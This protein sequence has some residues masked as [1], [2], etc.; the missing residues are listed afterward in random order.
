MPIITI[1]RGSYSKGKEVAE[2]VAQRLGYECISREVLVEASDHF[3]IPEIKLVRALHDAPSILERFTYGKERYLAYIESAFLDRVQNDNVVY[4]GLAGHFFLRGVG[5]VLKVRILADIEDRIRLEM[6]RE[7]IS[8]EQALYILKKDDQERRQWSMRLF[9]ADSWDSSLYDLVIHVKKLK[10]ED[11]VD[12][13][14]RTAQLEQFRT[15]LDSRN[16]LNDLVMAARVKAELIETCQGVSVT[17]QDGTIYVSAHARAREAP[18]LA[19]DLKS[20]AKKVPGVTD[21]RIEVGPVV[22]FFSD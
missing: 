4:H 17:A 18:Q 1:S 16:T 8:R 22:T 14:C 20:L 15:T 21:V 12:I 5:H 2:N 3:N 19:A 9:G 11:A 13:V 10:L 6:D 7:N